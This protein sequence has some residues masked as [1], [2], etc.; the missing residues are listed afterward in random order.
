MSRCC[1]AYLSV[2]LPSGLVRLAQVEPQPISVFLVHTLHDVE[3][4]LAQSLTH[5]VKEDQDQVTDIAWV[6]R[7]EGAM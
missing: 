4:A 7:W 1:C 2:R 6:G 3:G 5:G